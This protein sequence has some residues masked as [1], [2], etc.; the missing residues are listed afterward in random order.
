MAHDPAFLLYVDDF[1][2]GTY[3]MTNDQVGAYVRLLFVQFAN[4]FIT[5]DD[6]IEICGTFDEKIARKFSIETE[7]GKFQNE[8]LLIETEK[9]KSYS[10]SRRRNRLKGIGQRVI[11]FDH[12]DDK[13]SDH[14]IDICS[15]HDE[16]MKSENDVAD[17]KPAK[18]SKSKKADPKPADVVLPWD[19]EAF[20]AK[21]N[22]WKLYKGEQH[23][24]VYKPIGENNALKSLYNET[25]GDVELAIASINNSMARGWM[26]VIVTN[27]LK[28]K[29]GKKRKIAGTA[30]GRSNN[31]GESGSA[32][33]IPPSY[34]K[35]SKL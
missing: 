17:A 21:W 13:K 27:D 33:P 14:V 9:R 22:E 35:N 12:V 1:I 16:H 29:Y 3:R 5:R 26:G 20:S 34:Y 15:T 4:G 23:R 11:D 28:N 19:S 32:G 2:G 30:N 6:I 10:D 31:T 18:K 7:P 25:A 8:R 24:F